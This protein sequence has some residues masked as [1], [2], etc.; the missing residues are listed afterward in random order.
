MNEIWNWQTAQDVFWKLIKVVPVTLE[1][2]FLGFALAAV[3][4]LVWALMR[5]STF[6]PIS[7][8]AYWMIEFVR[9][10][11]LL[12]QLLFLYLALPR[13]PVFVI[14]VTGLGL[15]YSAYLAEVYRGGIEAVAQGQWEA[16]RALNFSPLK[17][18]TRIIL[19]QAIPPIIPVMGNYLIVLFKETPLLFAINVV[20]MMSVAKKFGSHTFQYTEA[21]TIVGVLFFLMSYPSS[22]L[23]RWAERRMA[24]K[25]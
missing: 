4:G 21:Y 24:L 11:P 8:L 2:T 20:E 25:H 3:L 16:A 23:V 17:T 22:L 10:T 15:H 7:L 18:W 1:A 12:V 14:G 13:F 19:P 9:S 6:R 5:R